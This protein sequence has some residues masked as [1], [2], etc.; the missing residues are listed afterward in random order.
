MQFSLNENQKKAVEY[1]RGPLLI[2]AGAG[3]GKT[4][5]ITQR[6]AYL[7]NSGKAK[8]SEILALTFTEKAASEMVERV[9]QLMP[10]GYEEVQISTF[11]SFCDR[12]LR[13]EGIHLG[14]D[15]NYSL[16]T[17]A[18]SYIFFRR[19][20]FDFSLDL[21]R[22]LGSPSQH[23]S[24]ILKH[25]SRLQDEDVS[26]EDYLKYAKSFRRNTEAKKEHYEEVNELATVYKELQ[27][28][29]HKESRLDFGDL[30]IT[31]LQL[32][33]KKPH[34]LERY[35]N[36]FKYILVDEFQ[37]TNFTQNVLVNML[38]L[39]KD[40]E[41]ATRALRKKAKI[42]VVGDDDQAIYKFRGAAISNIL[43]FKEVYPDCLRIV[44]TENYRSRQEI[45]D[46]AHQ[47]IQKND[48]YRLEETENIDKKLLAMAPFEKVV[49]DPVQ[50]IVADT[51][52]EEAEL[53]TK[54]V[55]TLTGNKD[56][57]KNDNSIVNKKYDS[58]GQSVFVDIVDESSGYNFNDIAVLVRANQHADEIIQALKSYGI[59]YKFTGP[60][61]LYNRPE[62]SPL[63]SFLKLL[64]DYTDSVEAFNLVKM[65]LWGLKPR[66][67]ID[68]MRLARDRKLS[69]IEFLEQRW[70]V[71][72][73][74]ENITTAFDP[75][76][77][78]VF[79]NISVES[80]NALGK[81]L[82]VL[83][84][85]IRETISKASL[86]SILY[87]FCLDSGYL[88]SF[89]N[90]DTYLAQFQ[91]QNIGKYFNV[92]KEYEL[93]NPGTDIYEYVN[94]LDYSI[95]IGESP[96]VDTDL[97]EGYNAVNILTVHSAKGLE[98][99]I[100]FLANLVSDRFPSRNRSDVLP[101]PDALV[102]EEI[103]ESDS[104]QEKLREERRLFYV[105]AT[106]A[107]EKLY[108]TAAKYYAGAKRKKKPSI[109]LDELLDRKV[110]D[111][112]AEDQD[113]IQKKNIL[114][115]PARDHIEGIELKELQSYLPKAFSYTQLKTYEL[116]PEK[117]FYQ[118]ILKLPAKPNSALS[119]GITVHAALKGLYTEFM[120]ESGGLKGLTSEINADRLVYIYNENWLN[121]GYENKRHENIRK[122]HG[123][124]ILR[125]FFSEFFSKNDKVLE[126]EKFFR[127]KLG[128]YIV[129][130]AIDRIDLLKEV[131]GVKHV[132]IID[133]KTGKRRDRK[134]IEK[135]LQL[136]LYALAA[137]SLFGVKVDKA[138][139]LFVEHGVKEE[140]TISDKSKNAARVKMQELI[141][142]II[143]GNFNAK[144]SHMCK[145][146][147]YRNICEDA[148]I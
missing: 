21:F 107:K 65:P 59:P 76:G 105:G 58:K 40:P 49:S 54:E 129:T 96:S 56:R 75:K 30:I 9:D 35:Q 60:K 116:C 84:K 91:V 98:F 86:T 32:F 63:I 101:I 52:N 133:Y 142:G 45:L 16:M 97:L 44:L 53:I 117:Y 121:I 126:L 138:S 127:Y 92:I 128:N 17:P 48:P 115:I 43:Q 99:P 145:Y 140:F 55:L 77:T 89:L 28:F 141:A 10:I 113:N 4:S 124:K 82:G 81:I 46:A 108:L 18:Q 134:E 1:D 42:T 11:H 38:M 50:L 85:G 64:T 72:I 110:S 123:E 23:I 13:Q 87:D 62:I 19:H 143:S 61:G 5:V 27:T 88:D 109:F 131:K 15:S 144:P 12:I 90:E 122:R 102:K 148:Q 78:S 31:V 137:E 106:R 136:P 93:S 74:D 7:I 112:F 25:F 29:K 26:P 114:I 111:D 70:E 80:S 104:K 94:Y 83:D 47:L 36:Q 6:I 22:P 68:I 57:L 135:D 73:G 130:G 3:T 39:G 8:S 118:Y 147:D 34:I 33:R 125:S 120:T 14:L 41:K 66:E 132:E 79:E 100:V 51:S 71:K 69:T 67:V 103:P 119:F 37:D 146:C 139:L 20:L 95:D 24:N 2:I